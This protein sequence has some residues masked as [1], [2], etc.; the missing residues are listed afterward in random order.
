MRRDCCV[1]PADFTFFFCPFFSSRIYK[2][3]IGFSPPPCCIPPSRGGTVV[4]SFVKKNGPR[5][6]FGGRQKRRWRRGCGPE[7]ETGSRPKIGRETRRREKVRRSRRRSLSWLRLSDE[8]LS[9]A[10]VLSSESWPTRRS[11][12][13][14]PHRIRSA[15]KEGGHSS[16]R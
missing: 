11:F 2:G 13:P 12:P 3:S 1:S 10:A 8:R 4:M 6:G 7:K 16:S 5:W 15:E 9:E 14:F